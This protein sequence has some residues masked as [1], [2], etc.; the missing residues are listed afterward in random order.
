MLVCLSDWEASICLP[1]CPYVPI[2]L[3]DLGASVHPICH[4]VFWGTS[5]HL[6]GISVSVSTS[7]YLSVHNNQTSCSPLL[8]AAS[9]CSGCLW[10]YAML[11]AVDLFFSCSVFI[12]SQASTTTA[13]TTTS[14]MTVVCSSMSS[15]L[16]TVTMAP[17]MMGLPVTSGQHDVVL[18]LPLTPR[19][20]G[21]LLA[22]PLCHSS[23]LC[24]R[25]LFRLMPIMQWILYR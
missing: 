13:A 17:Y 21:V 5:V 11:H 3:M 15:L 4:G 7:I 19:N 6:L 2:C 12:M 9:Y 20:S 16:S 18:P 24:L 10:M 22:L 8:W 23:N 14:P 1:V 25:C